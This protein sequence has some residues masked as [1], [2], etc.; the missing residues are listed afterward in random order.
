MKESELLRMK[1]LTQLLKVSK[2]TIYKWIKKQEFPEPIKIGRASAWLSDEV[3]NWLKTRKRGVI[4]VEK[5]I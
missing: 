1:D 3:Y 4:K 5:K 2:E